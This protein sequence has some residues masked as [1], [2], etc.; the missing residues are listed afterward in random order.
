M[1]IFPEEDVLTDGET[2][3]KVTATEIASSAESDRAVPGQALTLKLDLLSLLPGDLEVDYVSVALTK[4]DSFTLQ[5]GPP[6]SAVKV[7]D[8][9][10]L[11]RSSST[12]STG[13]IV[14]GSDTKGRTAS[15]LNPVVQE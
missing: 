3:V 7:K 11:R 1:S 14:D 4:D 6:A 9:K 5:E 12:A 10:E 2:L 15:L 8:K 13:R